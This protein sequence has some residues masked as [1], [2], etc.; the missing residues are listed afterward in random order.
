MKPLIFC[1][2]VATSFVLQCVMIN[3]TQ[4][5]SDKTSQVISIFLLCMS[6][7]FLSAI[8]I[9]WLFTPY[10]PRSKLPLI[11][12]SLNFG[13]DLISNAIFSIFYHQKYSVPYIFPI[14]S[15]LYTVISIA[16]ALLFERSTIG[17][18][19]TQ[20]AEHIRRISPLPGLNRSERDPCEAQAPDTKINIETTT[21][22]LEEPSSCVICLDEF[23]KDE[24]VNI[25][26]CK[27]FLHLQCTKDLVNNNIKICPVC[28]ADLTLSI[29]ECTIIN[30]SP[31]P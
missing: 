21:F 31:S 26:P 19:S 23:I 17:E 18:G 29:R 22:T 8:L 6:L 3:S 20:D 7:V 30:I 1:L 9:L 11:F 25:T 10:R 2:L 24:N 5:I 16:I 12:L 15:F 28:R 14:F 13:I 27:H 4:N